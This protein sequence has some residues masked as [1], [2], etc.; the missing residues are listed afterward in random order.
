MKYEDIQKTIEE[1]LQRLQ[2]SITSIERL[3]ETSNHV[4]FSIQTNDSKILIGPGGEHLKA[5]N[6][7]VKHI[8]SK[9]STDTPNFII[10]VNGYYLRHILEVKRNAKTLADRVRMFR[11][12]IEMSP[13]NAYDRML[14]HSAFA[15]D[16]EI[17]T[18]SEGEGKFRRVIL[19]VRPR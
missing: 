7:L 19:K 17:V 12:P 13:M 18:E 3:D 2:I 5:L 16:P 8:V 4:V 6:M 9:G 14:V 11:A 1:F 15:D 10:D